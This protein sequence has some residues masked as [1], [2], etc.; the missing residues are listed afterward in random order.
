MSGRNAGATTIHHSQINHSPIREQ[1]ETCIPSNGTKGPIE[2]EQRRLALDGVRGDQ[3]LDRRTF[4]PFSRAGQGD[5]GGL[6]MVLLGG[7]QNRKGG[8]VRSQ[9]LELPSLRTP[10]SNSCHT[11][12][13][14]PR[15]TFS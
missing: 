4:D 3:G 5:P 6:S 2:R 8:Q 1:L 7:H 10:E 15:A 13:G 9:L 12:P 14:I 11:M